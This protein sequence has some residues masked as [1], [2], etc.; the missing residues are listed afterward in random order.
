MSI[1]LEKTWHA[2][3]EVEV[4]RL[5]CELGVYQLAD[6]RGHVVRIGYAG[7]R[8]LFGLRG[9]LKN[10]LANHPGERLQF[11]VE[12]TSQYMSRYEELLMIHK[13]DHGGLPEHNAADRGRRI[14]RIHPA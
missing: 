13:A 7:G 4:S 11:R 5:G 9:E 1:R 3:N 14:G 10:E 6:E 2:L 8:S 12:I